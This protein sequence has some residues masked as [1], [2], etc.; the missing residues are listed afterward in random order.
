MTWLPR[1]VHGVSYLGLLEKEPGDLCGFV[2]VE[3]NDID[4][5][6]RFSR[7]I[8]R[9]EPSVYWRISFDPNIEWDDGYS[10]LAEV[11]QELDADKFVY[12]GVPYRVIWVDRK[13]QKFLE[14]WVFE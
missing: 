10:P 12:V 11:V 9:T 1:L 4:I 3:R 5:K 2:S 6:K 7:R 13:I 8:E 14:K